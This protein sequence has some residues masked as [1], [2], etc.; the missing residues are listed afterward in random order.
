MKCQLAEARLRPLV[1]TESMGLA[2]SARPAVGYQ[3]RVV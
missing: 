2:K 1:G 3:Q